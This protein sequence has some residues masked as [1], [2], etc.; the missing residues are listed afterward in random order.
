[1]LKFK[2]LFNDLQEY[3]SEQIGILDEA[4]INRVM[5]KLKTE[6]DFLVISAFRGENSVKENIKRNNDLIKYIRTELNQK[7]GAYRLVGHWLECKDVLG[8]GE[9]IKD[10]K[11][12]ENQI[13]ESWLIMK[14]EEI[15]LEELD[16]VAQKAAKEY[17]QDS[18]VIREDNKILLKG[19]DGSVWEDLGSVSKT[20]LEDGIKGIIGA[21]GY[22]ELKKDRA[23]G[24]ISNIVF[25]GFG[26]LAPKNQNS[27][28]MLFEKAGFLF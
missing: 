12:I 4:G 17:D 18:Y 26:V 21:Q 8:K 22:S 7:A 27:S 16:S 24:R 10:C 28:K 9:T 13:E 3:K 2:E 20:A 1:M 11:N 14:P 19:K 25:E 6:D 23:H 5:S 15:S